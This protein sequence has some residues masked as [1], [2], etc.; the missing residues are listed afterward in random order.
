MEEVEL[1]INDELNFL[2]AND[3]A[4]GIGM[5]WG[6]ACSNAYVSRKLHSPPHQS[7]S[8]SRSAQAQSCRKVR[9]TFEALN[10]C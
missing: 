10:S 9:I 7:I 4:W 6:G 8:D 2:E 3:V 5:Q 1:R